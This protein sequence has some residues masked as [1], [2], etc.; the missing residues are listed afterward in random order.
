MLSEFATLTL[1]RLRV[2]KSV[3]VPRPICIDEDQDNLVGGPWTATTL[4]RGS[5]LNDIFDTLTPEQRETVIDSV[6]ET[7]YRILMSRSRTFSKIGSI[8]RHQ[9]RQQMARDWFF[10]DVD[11]LKSQSAGFFVGPIAVCP[12]GSNGLFSNAEPPNIWHCG[13]FESADKWLAA[14]A[15]RDLDYTGAPSV[16]SLDERRDRERD[17]N[18]ILGRMRKEDRDFRK[19]LVLEHPA[20]SLSYILVDPADPTKIVSILGWSGAR[21]V[22]SW[23]INPPLDIPESIGHV[24]RMHLINKFASRVK[25]RFPEQ[26]WRNSGMFDKLLVAQNS[27]VRPENR[28][29]IFKGKTVLQ[30]LRND[31]GGQRFGE[32]TSGVSGFHY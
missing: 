25:E 5:F 28:S 21:V 4:T 15:S 14:I 12:P 31:R 7:Y 17:V 27:H 8:Y 22:P 11:D 3:P 10:T 23:A 9:D 13:P 2:P 24:E 1:L 29:L 30:R 18:E 19:I 6:A 26:H 32:K 16:L 20:F